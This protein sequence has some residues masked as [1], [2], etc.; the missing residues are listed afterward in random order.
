MLESKHP[1][2]LLLLNEMISKKQVELLGGP[3]NYSILPLQTNHERI[4]SSEMLTNF[5][6]KK[7]S[8]RPRGFWL[9]EFI[10]SDSLVS[11]IVNCGF[12]YTFH[13]QT[14]NEYYTIENTLCLTEENFKPLKIFK[15]LDA[16]HF[17]N[18][19][20]NEI[21]TQV[22][23]LSKQSSNLL[24]YNLT[25]RGESFKEIYILKKY[26]SPD[27]M[28]EKM[29]S[30]F[31]KNLL[32]FEPYLPSKYNKIV[33]S[34]IHRTYFA[35]HIPESLTKIIYNSYN[36]EIKN[37]F[38]ELFL[39]VKDLENYYA[40]INFVRLLL[41]NE[42]RG[43]KE[44]KRTGI[45][46]ISFC[47]PYDMFEFNK[48][49][50]NRE[51]RKNAWKHLL[52]AEKCTNGNKYLKSLALEQDYDLDGQT[53]IIVRQKNYD[54][55]I[56]PRTGAI[57]EF[58]YFP[59]LNNLCSV[60]T[61]QGEPTGLFLDSISLTGKNHI[62]FFNYALD[63][64]RTVV[65]LHSSTETINLEKSI[66]FTASSIIVNYTFANMYNKTVAFEFKTTSNWAL[67]FSLNANISE[68]LVKKYPNLSSEF[69]KSTSPL[70]KNQENYL[71]LS[72]ASLYP[73][74][75]TT[76]AIIFETKNKNTYPQGTKLES[77]WNVKIPP[78]ESLEIQF[79]VF[80]E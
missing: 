59:V 27:Y 78:Q 23:N 43:D 9:P 33:S 53:E 49:F 39:G 56:N 42:I 17:P 26:E 69:C 22:Q 5:I 52:E 35:K 15:T 64:E 29:F 10:W 50:F 21:I 32:E 37:D 38:A 7:F 51:C 2:F 74:V 19:L 66:C 79:I 61:A 71:L 14:P 36:R 4:A 76:N 13:H 1:E 16:S 18:L 60:I 67:D 72:F 70:T 63:H 30:W 47:F 73:C 31:R 28:M 20:P 40:K 34:N 75:Y 12:E 48:G 65:K 41:K 45:D 57:S 68:T 44:R 6:R 77:T 11:S 55:V 80:I 58:D 25:I 3:F 24:S 62:E 8:K 54:C 46:A